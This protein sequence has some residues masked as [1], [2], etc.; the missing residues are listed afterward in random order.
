MS[1]TDAKYE[2]EIV[3]ERNKISENSNKEMSTGRKVDAVHS[4][5]PKDANTAIWDQSFM[6]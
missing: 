6:S 4:F 3:I 1:S 5:H 2:R